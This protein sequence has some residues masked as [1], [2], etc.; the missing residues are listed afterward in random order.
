MFPSQEPRRSPPGLFSAVCA[1]AV[2]DPNPIQQFN[3]WLNES[4]ER[5]LLEPNAMTVASVDATGQ[6]WTRTILL[7][8]C[9]DRGFTFFTHYEGAKDLGIPRPRT[10][11]RPPSPLVERAGSAQ[12]EC[13]YRHLVAKSSREE[14][15]AYF[16]SRPASSQIGAWASAQSE[17][18][19]DR[20]QLE[21]PIR[22]GAGQYAAVGNPAAAAPG[23]GTAVGPADHRILAGPPQPPARPPALH[24][25]ARRSEWKIERLSAVVRGSRYIK[26]SVAPR[27][28]HP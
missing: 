28:I 5:Q 20:E 11:A 8:V 18:V 22:R 7:K 1:G 6:P 14:S 24:A 27:W 21:N 3:A 2:S 15:A 16:H 19:A 12:A 26:T 4:V 9:D 25:A 17:V 23:R 13:V 10:R